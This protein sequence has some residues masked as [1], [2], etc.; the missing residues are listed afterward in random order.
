[1][2]Y[3]NYYFELEHQD[4]PEN[5]TSGI[6]QIFIEAHMPLVQISANPFRQFEYMQLGGGSRYFIIIYNHID[7]N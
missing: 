3:C 4:Y 1:M 2:P 6:H 5:I 7:Q